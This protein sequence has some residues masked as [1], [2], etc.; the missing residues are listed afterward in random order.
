MGK[1]KKLM[2]LLAC[3]AMVAGSIAGC[4]SSSG[5]RLME[6]YVHGKYLVERTYEGA[7]V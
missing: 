3:T 1:M 5:K 7:A 2:A 4:G 6:E